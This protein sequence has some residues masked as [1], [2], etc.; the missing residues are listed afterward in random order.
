MFFLLPIALY[1]ILFIPYISVIPS[2]DG[3]LEFILA[4]D[5]YT[6]QNRFHLLSLH[7]PAKYILFSFFYQIFG[8]NSIGYIG[9]LLGAAG[10]YALYLIAKKFFD[11]KIAVLSAMLL[12]TSGLYISVGLF[13]I[14]DFLI[15]VFLLI[16]YAAYLYSR[17]WLYALLASLAVL[18]KEPA[19]F[20]P[21][22][23]LFYELF[24]KRKFS[25]T[26][27]LPVIVFLSYL[28]YLYSTGNHI[29]NEWNFSNTANKGSIYTMI[30]N[31]VT[32]QFLNKYAYE[33]WLHLFVFNFNWVYWIFTGI[34]FFYIK[35]VKMKKELIPIGIFFLSFILMPL[36][37]QTFT[38]TRYILPLL[39]FLYM[40]AVFGVSKMRF[41]PVF[42]ILLVLITLIS[43]FQS[44]DPVSNFFWKKIQVFNQQL[45]LSPLGGKDSITYNMQYLFLMKQ[46]TDMIEHNH[47]TMPDVIP[48]E[49]QTLVLLHIKTCGAQ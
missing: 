16:A 20:F 27:L 37:F 28:G 45:Y 21:L 38:I 1:I 17:F 48:Y 41:K 25:V 6:N 8:Y 3:N 47:C 24:I 18:T 2:N 12:A 32:F 34:S 43:L 4:N 22:S 5:W 9:L 23:I 49:T 19:L 33:N 29:W 11:K 26:S 30:N 14:H 36:S 40:F 44:V 35:T 31:L 42:A 39:P 13:S 46:R 7:P 10:I 15:T